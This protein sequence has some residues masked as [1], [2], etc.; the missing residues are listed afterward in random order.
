MVWLD[1]MIMAC[2][3]RYENLNLANMPPQQL[4]VTK[5]IIVRD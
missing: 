4:E 5:E 1:T 2:S 3:P